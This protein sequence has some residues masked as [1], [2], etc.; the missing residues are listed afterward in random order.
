VL[1][2]G[3]LCCVACAETVTITRGAPVGA[4]VI[5]LEDAYGWPITYEAPPLVYEG[6]LTDVTAQNR[7]DGKHAGEPGVLQQLI[8]RMETFSFSF[9]PPQQRRP[10]TRAPETEARRAILDMLKSYSESIGGAEVFRLADSDGLFH[11]IPTQRK[12]VSGQWEKIVPLLDTPVAMS[13]GSRTGREF[14][15]EICRALGAKSGLPQGVGFYSSSYANWLNRW[16]TEIASAPEESARS[17]LSRFAAEQSAPRAV[18]W[19]LGYINNWGWALNV[20]IIDI[21]RNDGPSPAPQ[22]D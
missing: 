7:N 22:K 17:I 2:A 15:N 9:D 1:P 19:S 14:I 4:A 6:D 12:G 3:L 18:S 21:N 16:K 10:G 8:P 13:P 5:K 20:H 11:I